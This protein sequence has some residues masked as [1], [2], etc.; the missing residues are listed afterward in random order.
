MGPSYKFVFDAQ[1]IGPW[2]HDKAGGMFSIG[3]AIGVEDENGLFAGV[4]YDGYTGANV[5]MSSRC[6]N[7]AKMPRK[8]YSLIFDY[9]FNQLKVKRISVI[10]DTNNVKAQ[11]VNE[12]LGFQREHIMR[13]YFPDGDAILYVMRRDDCRFLEGKYAL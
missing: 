3:T 9:P 12:H 8:F 11:K 10:V 7:P 4:T 2:V 5:S 13:D 6:D 1:R